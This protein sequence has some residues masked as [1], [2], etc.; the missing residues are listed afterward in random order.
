MGL[1]RIGASALATALALALAPGARAEVAAEAEEVAA[2]ESP[3]ALRAEVDAPVLLSATAIWAL[4]KLFQDVLAQGGCLP[5]DPDDVNAFDRTAIGFYDGGARIASHV[6]AVGL[7]VLAGLGS[8]LDV[9][10]FG[11]SAALEDVVIVAESIAISGAVTGIVKNLAQRPRPYMYVEETAEEKGAARENYLSFYSG[12]TS[13]AFS[14]VVSFAYL[15]SVRRP[16]SPWRYAVWGI[17]I[18]AASAV[19]VCRV[20]SGAHFWT[21]V[22]TSAAVSSAIGLVTPVLHLRRR[23]ARADGP[24]ARATAGPGYASFY[25]RF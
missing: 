1:G 19:G 14:A 12:H 25:V 11:W 16:D 2:P 3:F 23:G 6:G 7:P 10:P 21:D 5:C 17:G 9:K 8:L 24:E 22:V 4:P 18:A 20:L 13:T 15:F